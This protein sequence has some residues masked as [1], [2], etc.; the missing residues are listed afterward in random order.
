[1]QSQK[2]FTKGEIFQGEFLTRTQSPDDP[3][4]EVPERREHGRNLT[5]TPTTRLVPTQSF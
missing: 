4:D 2:L 1:M 3:A 5:G